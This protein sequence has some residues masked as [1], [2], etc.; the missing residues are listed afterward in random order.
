VVEGSFEVTSAFPFRKVCVFPE[1]TYKDSIIDFCVELKGKYRSE[2]YLVV[3]KKEEREVY[4]EKYGDRIAGCFVNRA[5]VTGLLQEHPGAEAVLA[6]AQETEKKYGTKIMHSVISDRHM[7]RGF[8]LGAPYFPRSIFSEKAEYFRILKVICDQY[9]YFER[10]F[11]EHKIDFVVGGEKVV[12]DVCRRLHITQRYFAPYKYKTYAYWGIN[13]FWES[14]VLER[15]YQETGVAGQ[16]GDT[17]FVSTYSGIVL[18]KMK[19]AL[20]RNTIR[21]LVRYLAQRASWW[22]KGYEKSK[23]YLMRD[24]IRY[25]FWNWWRMGKIRKNRKLSSDSC[26][27]YDYIFFPLHLEPERAMTTFS[28]EFFDQIYAIMTLSKE[29]PAGK[30][31]VVKEHLVAVPVRPKE[32]YR[33]LIEMQNVLFA[34]PF[35]MSEGFIANSRGVVAITGTAGFEAAILGKP[36]ICFGQHNLYNFLPHV[37]LL[38]GWNDV[39]PVLSEVFRNHTAQE[40]QRWIADGKRF[41][42]A[43]KNTS[44]NMT[45]DPG[46]NRCKV[47]EELEA[48][49][50]MSLERG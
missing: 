49:L 25:I 43:F 27:K 37:H 38:K 42:S 30:F 11:V 8:A 6:K 36:V 29:L 40:E 50:L 16:A 47:F 9:D 24:D 41:I 34:D 35:E 45:D 28:P 22:A 10:M 44:A 2:I 19:E 39:A 20:L 46:R 1:T 21:E 26:A 14:N 12:A 5:L 15:A 18:R 23:G 4:L 17:D 31:L 3:T 13:E 48:T 32:F 33:Q 7:G